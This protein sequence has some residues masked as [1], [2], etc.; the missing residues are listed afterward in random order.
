MR[1][2]GGVSLQTRVFQARAEP[3]EASSQRRPSSWQRG[4]IARPLSPPPS[5]SLGK[6]EPR[7]RGRRMQRGLRGDDVGGAEEKACAPKQSSHS[8]SKARAPPGARRNSP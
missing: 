8:Q 1:P 6:P 3:P 4:G 7:Q 5:A 2:P